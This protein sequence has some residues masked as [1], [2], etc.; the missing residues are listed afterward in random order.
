MG[1]LRG[2]EGAQRGA[3]GALRGAEGALLL[4]IQW[5]GTVRESMKPS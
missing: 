5:L 1:T 4:G 3:E 2:A